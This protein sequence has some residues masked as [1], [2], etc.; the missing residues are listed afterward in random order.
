MDD[1]INI[2]AIGALEEA[3]IDNLPPTRL[4]HVRDNPFESLSDSKFMKTYHLTKPMV[5]ELRDIVEPF[6]AAASRKSA[7]CDNKS[8]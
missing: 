6:I 4:F 5:S 3:E 2:A 7:L 1:I 8:M